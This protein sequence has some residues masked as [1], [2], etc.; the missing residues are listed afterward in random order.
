MIADAHGHSGRRVV[1]G[2]TRA[3]D[4]RGGRA[5]PRCDGLSRAGGDCVTRPASPS[6]PAPRCAWPAASRRACR[7]PSAACRPATTGCPALVGPG[8]TATISRRITDEIV[9]IGINYRFGPGPLGRVFIRIIRTSGSAPAAVRRRRRNPRMMPAKDIR[10]GAGHAKTRA[11][12]AGGRSYP[13]TI[14]PSY[15]LCVGM[16]RAI[17]KKNAGG[18]GRENRAWRK[19]LSFSKLPYDHQPRRIR[20][21]FSPLG[22]RAS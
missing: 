18:R 4:R 9:R 13:C 6:S 2:S 21:R 22:R 10:N 16:S 19:D 12:G 20:G 14:S 3:G 5:A 15:T 1:A 8:N 11:A 17:R 7:A